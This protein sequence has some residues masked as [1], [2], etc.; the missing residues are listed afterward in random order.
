MPVWLLATVGE[1]GFGNLC[2]ANAALDAPPAPVAAFVAVEGNYLG[3]VS[4]IGVG[5]IRRRFRLRGPGGHAWEAA[6]Q[7]SAVH[8]L[9]EMVASIGAIP[10][11]ERDVRERRS[12]RRRR[13]HQRAGP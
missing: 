7:P 5:S 11:R 3:R 8:V 6:D 9:A 10:R 2:G 13:G 1:E 4:T 12:D